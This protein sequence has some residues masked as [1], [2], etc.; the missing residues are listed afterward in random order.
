MKRALALYVAL[1]TAALVLVLYV[2]G[3]EEL[4]RVRA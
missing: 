2:I 1:T 3:A 4:R